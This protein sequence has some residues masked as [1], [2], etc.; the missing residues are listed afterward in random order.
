MCRIVC[1]HRDDSLKIEDIIKKIN[2]KYVFS[3]KVNN[4]HIY[5]YWNLNNKKQLEDFEQ[6]Y[7]NVEDMVYQSEF[8]VLKK[9]LKME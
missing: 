2:D 6:D 8:K 9:Y 7:K 1:K 3:K 4:K 5:F